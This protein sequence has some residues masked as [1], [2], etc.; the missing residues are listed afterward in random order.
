MKTV[1]IAQAKIHPVLMILTHSIRGVKNL[2][3]TL[4][5]LERYT[6]LHSFIR[7]YILANAS[8][9]EHQLLIQKYV[10]KYSGPFQDVHCSPAGHTLCVAHMK[11]IIH[12][13]HFK[14]VIL[15]MDNGMVEM[16]RA[17]N[18]VQE[19]VVG[20]FTIDCLYNYVMSRGGPL[21]RQSLN[22]PP[23]AYGETGAVA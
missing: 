10:K 22:Q 1:D 20:N 15:K 21:G 7:I 23:P 17:F 16:F 12:E 6:G 13:M 11:N 3:I 8:F 2:L 9:A 18:P 14:D 5:C 19:E 4:R